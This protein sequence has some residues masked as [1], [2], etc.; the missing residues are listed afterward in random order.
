LFGPRSAL[1]TELLAPL[2]CDVLLSIESDT[3]IFFAPRGV[4]GGKMAP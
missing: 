3:N 2:P 4:M 1:L